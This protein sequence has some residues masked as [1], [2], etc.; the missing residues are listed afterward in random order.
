MCC[1]EAFTASATTASSPMASAESNLA[2]VRELLHV[3]PDVDVTPEQRDLARIASADLRLPRVWGAHDH[4]RDLGARTDPRPATHAERT[5]SASASR[6]ANRPPA[7]LLSE[8]IGQRFALR[9]DRL[10][11]RAAHQ[12][13]SGVSTPAAPTERRSRPIARL[14]RHLQS[15]AEPQI[16]I[17]R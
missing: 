17:A 2:K 3:A 9:S 6:H 4:H 16:P 15:E 14:P 7:L 1:P 11:F 5:M 8:P 10:V 12:L 13:N